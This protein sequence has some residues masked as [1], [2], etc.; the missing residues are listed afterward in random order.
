MT[1]LEQV[2]DATAGRLLLWLCDRCDMAREVS[3]SAMQWAFVAAV[4][5]GT[6]WIW[7]VYANKDVPLPAGMY[8]VTKS[9]VS[10]LYAIDQPGLAGKTAK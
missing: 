8:R 2:K 7:T 9:G 3:K 6:A 4:I 10:T 1:R 5:W